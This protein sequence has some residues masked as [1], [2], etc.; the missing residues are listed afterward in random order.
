MIPVP[1]GDESG[2]RCELHYIL[3]RDGFTKLLPI[4]SREKFIDP[5][6]K[7]GPEGMVLQ[8]NVFIIGK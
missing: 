1:G 8:R 7:E 3:S 6:R 2:Y 5:Y 4:I